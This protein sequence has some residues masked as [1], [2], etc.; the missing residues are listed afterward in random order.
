MTKTNRVFGLCFC[1]AAVTTLALNILVSPHLPTGS[2]GVVAASQIYFARQLI[3]ASVAFILVF[4]LVG[5]SGSW[6]YWPRYTLDTF[7]DVF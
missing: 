5:L 3:A 4:A 7:L 1:V 6:S 2:F